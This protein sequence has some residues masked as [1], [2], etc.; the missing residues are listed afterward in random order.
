MNSAQTIFTIFFAI[1][2]AV[3][4]NS[5]NKL[6]LFDTTAMFSSERCYPKSWKRFGLSILIMNIIPLLYFEIIM[7]KLEIIKFEEAYANFGILLIIFLQ[8]IIGFGFYRILFGI[9]MYREKGSG[10]YYF[11]EKTQYKYDKVPIDEVLEHRSYTQN[12]RIAHIVP[13]LLW[14]L[15]TYCTVFLLPLFA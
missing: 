11:Y 15:L 10:D 1:Y 12:E 9:L 14:V 2:F 5:T 8:S 13:G 4:I 6:D 7:G 3:T